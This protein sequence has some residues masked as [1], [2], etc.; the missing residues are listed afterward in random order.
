M[1]KIF[2]QITNMSLTASYC[3]LFVYLARTIL[4]KAPKIYSYLLWLIVAFRL[5]CPV[6]FEST[7][8]FLQLNAFTVLTDITE[9]ASMNE[10]FITKGNVQANEVSLPAENTIAEKP[11]ISMQLVMKIS[12]LVWIIGSFILITFSF[13][14]VIRLK[15]KLLKNSTLTQIHEGSILIWESE[16]LETPFVLGFFKPEVYLPAGLPAQERNY[17]LAHEI[18]HIT[19]KDHLVK[20]F[21]HLLVCAHW[22]NPFV[23]FAFHL[24]TCDMEMSCD[25][26]VIQELGIKDKK[27][28][29]GTLLA[30][31]TNSH[32]QPMTNPLAFGEKNVSRR[33]KNIMNYKKPGF[34][35]TI[36]CV[37]AVFGLTV[38]LIANPKQTSSNQP[39]KTNESQQNNSPAQQASQQSEHT[40]QAEAVRLTDQSAVV[41]ADSLRV[42][43][44][45]SDNAEIIGL[46]SKDQK[47]EILTPSADTEDKDMAQDTE[48]YAAILF[49]YE[50]GEKVTAYV[51]LRYLDIP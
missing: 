16:R 40:N 23:W 29:S 7:F 37:I 17:C 14:S 32:F 25:E 12:S 6:S 44:L 43:A 9:D 21:A 30:L 36:V 41:I 49:E 46:L 48:K 8:S 28:Y 38:G 51:Q 31:A 4:K 15:K 22:F 11:L 45:P 3:I 42:R 20:Q 2:T 24:M 50:N 13:I 18:T 34:W 27:Q 26:A 35:I 39:A 10:I 47:V 19:R 33:I 1:V 5:V